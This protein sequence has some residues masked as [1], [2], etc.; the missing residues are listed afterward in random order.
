M[1]ST[2]MTDQLIPTAYVETTKNPLPANKKCEYFFLGLAV[3]FLF[4]VNSAFARCTDI[5]K[6]DLSSK[7]I[8]NEISEFYVD[9]DYLSRP[10][11]KRPKTNEMQVY[12][13][14]YG[15]I[16][17]SE[18]GKSI[19]EKIIE[20][21]HIAAKRTCSSL[22]IIYINFALS[23]DDDRLNISRLQLKES[24]LIFLISSLSDYLYKHNK[25]P[26]G[27]IWGGLYEAMDQ[28]NL[29]TATFLRTTYQQNQ[30]LVKILSDYIPEKRYESLHLSRPIER[31]FNL[32]QGCGWDKFG[33]CV[34][35]E[36]IWK[37]MFNEEISQQEYWKDS[38]SIYYQRMQANE[39]TK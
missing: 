11:Y 24:A 16:L 17:S 4:M 3:Y 21:A 25:F 7:D 38:L 37:L 28:Y 26:L 23:L 6:L 35:R 9:R 10:R 30:Y 19:Q 27:D 39:K 1:R 32:S 2:D 29:I 34:A 36:E 20:T 18:Y 8:M 14:S 33:W 13:V 31:I 22:E 15:S 12:V 5:P